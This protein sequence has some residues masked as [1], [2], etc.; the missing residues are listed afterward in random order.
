V[1]DKIAVSKFLGLEKET[2]DIEGIYIH[3]IT[4]ESKTDSVTLFLY[5]DR[6]ICCEVTEFV[7]KQTCKKFNL[8][9]VNV[10]CIYPEELD[11]ETVI[12]EDLNGILHILEKECPS[13]CNI[14][15]DCQWSGEGN[16]LRL[17]LRG[18][19]GSCCSFLKIRQFDK[20]IKDFFERRYRITPVL[21]ICW[22]ED[23]DT[24]DCDI[25]FESLKEEI[26]KQEE[27]IPVIEPAPKAGKPASG[28]ESPTDNANESKKPKKGRGRNR[29]DEGM[30]YGKT[31]TEGPVPIETLT[32][33]TGTC[34]IKG[35]VIAYESVTLKS[36]DKCIIKFDI[37]DYTD[38]VTC[39]LFADV[40]DEPYFKES[41]KGQTVCVKGSALYDTFDRDLCVN[42]YSIAP[43]EKEKEITDN[44]PVK[45]VELHAHTKMSSMDGVCSTSDLV[46]LAIRYGHKAVAITDHGVVQAFPEA[47]NTK[48]NAKSD[49][50]I[51]YGVE[52]YLTDSVQD[53]VNGES[54]H[55]IVLVQNQTGL[56]N[57]YKLISMSHL[58]YF[59]KHPKMPREVLQKYR[60]VLIL[61]SA[62][63]AGELYQAILAKKSPEEI[64]KIVDFYDYLEIQ[65]NGNNMFMVRNGLLHSVQ[66]IEDINR[67][68]VSLAKE[69]GK[70]VVATCDVHFLR[71]KDSVFRKLLMAGQGYSD[72]EF[73]AP[74][75]FRTTEE[76][77]AE[78]QYLGADT[79]YEVVVTNTN[80]IAERIENLRPVPKG[81]YTPEIEGA[82]EELENSCMEKAKEIYGDP[83]PEIVSDRLKRELKAIIGN[84]FAVMYIIARKLVLKSVADGYI[85]GSRGSV[86]S[87][88]AAHMCGITEVNALPPHYVCRKCKHSEFI[89]DGSYDCGHDMPDKVCPKC[90]SLYAKDGFDIPFETFLGFNGEKAPDIDL[91]FA[92]E[93][94]PVAHK[95]TE[96]LFGEGYTYRAGTIGTL[97]EK[98]AMGFVKGYFD[99]KG[100]PLKKAEMNRLIAGCT[101]VKRTTGQHPGG[102]VVIPKKYEVYDFCPI[103]HPA[104]AKESDIITT[105]FDFH[106]I[107]DTILKLD[108]LGHDD[109][110]TI[111]MLEDLTG[112]KATDIPL[113]DDKVLSL[114]TSTEALGVRPEDIDSTTGTLGLPETG[115]DFVRGVLIDTQPKMVSDLIRVMGLT[116]GT[117]VWLNNAQKLIL[118]N[119]LTLQEVICNRDD[120]MNYLIKA[121]LEPFHAFDIME[122]VRKGKG[123]TEKQEALM[124]EKDVPEWY[125]DS[126]K[127]IKY[128]FPKAH[129]A[130]YAMMALRIGWFKVYR[131]VAF[132]TAYF[133]V[134]GEDFDANIM[135]RGKDKAKAIYLE[136]KKRNGNELSQKEK[137]ILTL[138]ALVIEM[139]ERGIEMLP[140]DIYKSEALRFTMEEGKIRPSLNSLSGLGNNAAL[141]IAEAR[142]KGS[143][144]S[145]EDLRLSAKVGKNV[146]EI[147]RDYG[148]L[149]GMPGDNQMTIF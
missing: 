57:L 140:V 105:H 134:R 25:E 98:T 115:T 34:V 100:I 132:Y 58:D 144:K 126:C 24:E 101:G 52:A 119:G 123:L 121:G 20:I 45:R 26:R 112:I 89:L 117:D 145:V 75:Y 72:A 11:L 50:K 127:K 63:E 139:Y 146:I 1:K 43:A 29:T 107:S 54:Y 23:T 78:F 38:S 13:V 16:T 17:D 73:Q 40:N 12:Q 92:G 51:I 49:I 31:I 80:Q 66:D 149:D 111:K 106:S 135:T 133:S 76:M 68:I 3:N 55:C 93:Y 87:S 142:K 148:C 128:M 81:T 131:P 44:S 69:A 125:I 114:F 94:Q 32:P 116:H 36:G 122:K 143:F 53:V 90:G 136:L 85:V 7:K 6:W 120:I 91:N 61:G 9:H 88:F 21:E 138:L 79:A 14:V 67:Y 35:D 137:N 42:V 84:G 28:G 129:A 71:E 95:Y 104:D 33:V 124:R 8:E 62:C 70:P 18:L 46:K 110:T 77:L 37:T 56:K 48:E 65:P 10:A 113:H 130:A 109:P 83:L 147:L 22:P 103:Q 141:S 15:K 102:I 82:E 30:I 99:E 5:S 96:E 60:E 118:E 39:K 47:M 2:K 59:Y 74:L 41:L 27:L 97:A 64:R 86:G 19:N 4:V 108:I